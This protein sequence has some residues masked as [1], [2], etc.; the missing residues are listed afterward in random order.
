MLRELSDVIQMGE[1]CVAL[2]VIMFVKYWTWDDWNIY[3]LNVGWY[4]YESI[5]LPSKVMLNRSVF[6]TLYSKYQISIAGTKVPGALSSSA[7][8]VTMMTFS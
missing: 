1:F 3:T 2:T 4:S 8:V 6:L 7:L 5:Y